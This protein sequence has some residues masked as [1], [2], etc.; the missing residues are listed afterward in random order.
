MV[1]ICGIHLCKLGTGPG[2]QSCR[3]ARSTTAWTCQRWCRQSLGLLLCLAWNLPIWQNSANF[4]GQT[5]AFVQACSQRG[6]K[7]T[8]SFDIDVLLCPTVDVPTRLSSLQPYKCTRREQNI[9]GTWWTL[10][11]KLTNTHMVRSNAL[12]EER[13]WVCFEELHQLI[14]LQQPRKRASYSHSNHLQRESRIC[15]GVSL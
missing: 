4:I 10:Q 12:T 5:A 8:H 14:L 11:W 15:E 13:F 7:Y 1:E 3:E 6:V 9:G 2:Q